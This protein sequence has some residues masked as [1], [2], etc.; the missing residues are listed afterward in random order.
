MEVISLA[1]IQ[2]T[3]QSASANAPDI[4]WGTGSSDFDTYF[5]S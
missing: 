2:E 1:S 3:M 4:T 5:G